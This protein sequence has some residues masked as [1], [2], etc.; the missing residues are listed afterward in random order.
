MYEENKY[1][2]DQFNDLYKNDS[3][4]VKNTIP[5]NATDVKVQNKNDEMSYKM[6]NN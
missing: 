4:G 1:A 3:D 6:W 5:M 2:N